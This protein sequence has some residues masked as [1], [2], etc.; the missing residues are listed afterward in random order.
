M[1]AYPSAKIQQ[2][3]APG[4]GPEEDAGESECVIPEFAE[5]LGKSEGSAAFR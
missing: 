2:T 1:G 3:A 4:K 5:L